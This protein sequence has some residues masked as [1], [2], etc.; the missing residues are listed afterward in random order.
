M[1]MIDNALFWTRSSSHCKYL[2][3]AKKKTGAG[4]F[5]VSTAVGWSRRFNCILN[6]NS[7]LVVVID[8]NY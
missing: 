5:V 6:S 8:H 1:Q 7:F 3:R 4:I 2:G